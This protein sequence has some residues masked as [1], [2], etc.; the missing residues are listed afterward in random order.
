MMALSFVVVC[1]AAA[2]FTTAS[3]IVDRIVCQSIDWIEPEII[4]HLRT[5]QGAESARP[6]LLW[7]EITERSRGAR[8]RHGGHFEGQPGK[9]DALVARRALQTIRL[10]LSNIAAVLLIR[11]LDDQPERRTGLEQA[12]NESDLKDQI[13]I[14]LAEPMRECWVLAGFEPL[15]DLENSVLEALRK[16]LKF[17]PREKAERLT[18]KHD[19][20][21]RSPKRVLNRLTRNARDREAV[22]WNDAKLDTLRERGRDTGLAAFIQEVEERIVPLFSRRGLS[23]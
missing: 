6:F 7:K 14:G 3:N 15:D 12:R 2:D 1:E 21:I 10:K 5:Y 11:D 23:Q 22:C 13:V 19:H 20:E 16:E 4:V 18:A 9:A 8:V 17:D